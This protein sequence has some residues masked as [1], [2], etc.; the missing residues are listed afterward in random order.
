MK[1]KVFIVLL[2]LSVLLNVVFIY[3]FFYRHYFIKPKVLT[4]KTFAELYKEVYTF[5]PNDSNEVIF[6]GNS[7]TAAFPVAELSS[8]NRIKN[9]GISANTSI[10]ILNRLSE[11]T[12]SQ[13]L[14]IFI[15]V[16]INDLS[17][18][19]GRIKL[20]ENFK[21]IISTIK[22][23]SPETKIYIQSILPVSKHASYYFFN[24]SLIL[25]EEIRKA[26]EALREISD[27]RGIKY[28]DLYGE[29]LEKDELNPE[30]SWDGIHINALGYLRW[31]D[32]I[33]SYIDDP[34][35]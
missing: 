6:L 21:Q 15:L 32:L 18:G 3:R 1:Q 12:E 2:I 25:D 28:V 4:S 22:F 29:F 5:C 19:E 7:I 8:S 33:K 24:D 11:I 20:I 10:D 34:D 17:W 31:Y 9:R 27:S 35:N 26:N 14:K 30:Y 16:G 13:P 23:Q